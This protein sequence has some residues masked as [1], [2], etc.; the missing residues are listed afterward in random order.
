MSRV[1]TIYLLR[2]A[3]AASSYEYEDSER[4]LT[5]LGKEQ[6]AAIGAHFDEAGYKPDKIL[7]SSATRTRETLENLK[8]D[9]SK[10][11]VNIEP[12]LYNAD[13]RMLG[14]FI[15]SL[16]DDV[17]SVLVIGHNPGLFHAAYSFSKDSDDCAVFSYDLA[18]L[19]VFETELDSWE[20]FSASKVFCKKIIHPNI[21]TSPDFSS[22]SA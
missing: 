16:D 17:N 11:S 15:A 2:H 5:A 8:L 3:Q 13:E 9:T 4:P 7:C 21:I 10:T 6:A 22:K 1:R 20:D 18:M 19:C 12:R 14:Q